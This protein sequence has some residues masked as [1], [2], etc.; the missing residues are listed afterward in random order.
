MGQDRAD[1]NKTPTCLAGT[2]P[3]VGAQHP[4]VQRLEFSAD[5]RTADYVH[6]RL[7]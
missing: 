6:G 7:G 5:P 2:E 4:A 1:R 3:V